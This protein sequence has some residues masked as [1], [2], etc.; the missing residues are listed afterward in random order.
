LKFQKIKRLYKDEKKMEGIE[1]KAHKVDQAIELGL[2]ELQI[3]ADDATIEVISQ[4]GLFSKAVVRIT[5]K[6]KPEQEAVDFINNLFS[7]M[8]FD[9]FAS[10]TKTDDDNRIEITGADSAQLIGYRGDILDSVQYV[11]LL[12]ANK[13]TKDFVRISVNT[14][15]YREKRKGILAGLAKKLAQKADRTGRKVELEPMNPYERR[16]IHSTL[17]DSEIV[18]TESV[19]EEP[20]RYIVI[21]PKNPRPNA[22]RREQRSGGR[23]FNRDKKYGGYNNNRERSG[24][25]GGY[26]GRSG[27]YGG[28]ERRDL[29]GERSYGERTYNNNRGDGER[30]YNNNRADGERTYNNNRDRGGYNGERGYNN[31]GDRGGY[32]GYNRRDGSYEPRPR[33]DYSEDGADG[34]AENVQRETSA[35]T[36]KD[37][38]EANN[39]FSNN[40][41]KNGTKNFKS[42]GYKRR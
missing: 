32:G 1:F 7:Y 4:G 5:P 13:K 41:K 10:L 8:K 36:E 18:T 39:N 25:R 42:F 16:V 20:N 17:Q 31:E 37:Y 27:G 9:A 34:I 11:A 30:S 2:K 29:G 14:E 22:D 3:T 15:N 38:S 28:A 6:I 40:F 12:I 23:T 35:E 26:G 19:G 33:P 21:V 24:G